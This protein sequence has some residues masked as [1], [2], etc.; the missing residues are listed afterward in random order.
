VIAVATT[1][2]TAR[3][4]SGGGSIG[5]SVIDTRELHEVAF[6]SPAQGRVEAMAMSDDGRRLLALW[7]CDYG[8]APATC[9]GTRVVEHGIDERGETVRMTGGVRRGET[10]HALAYDTEGRVFALVGGTYRYQGSGEM[11]PCCNFRLLSQAAGGDPA[12]PVEVGSWSV[13][14]FQALARPLIEPDGTV[15]LFGPDAS[16]SNREVTLRPGRAPAI[17]DDRGAWLNSLGVQTSVARGGQRFLGVL[18]TRPGWAHV[19]HQTDDLVLIERGQPG[20]GAGLNRFPLA[21]DV[22]HAAISADG[23]RAVFISQPLTGD[24]PQPSLQV[25]SLTSG[26]ESPARPSLDLLRLGVGRTRH[27]S[28]MPPDELLTRLKALVDAGR[29]DDIEVVAATLGLRISQGSP[30]PRTHSARSESEPSVPRLLGAGY[31]VGRRDATDRIFVQLD[32]T[33]G[34]EV[35]P[36]L[37]TA[38][39]ER[40]FGAPQLDMM[41][42]G[43]PAFPWRQ[44]RWYMS[45]ETPTNSV[46]FSFRKGYCAG[47]VM[48]RQVL[49]QPRTEAAAP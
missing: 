23:M 41:D 46:H 27:R 3:G 47:S 40:V 30:D 35:D 44:P 26:D 48:L 24:N 38:A 16:R 2:P 49:S 28:G 34:R 14:D 8:V 1:R 18:A 12:E 29:L 10:L 32:L 36:C 7:E 6:I 25:I 9:A 13:P 20:E 15:R 45:Y 19:N 42:T 21:A 37:T 22:R 17:S 5:F 33:L 4:H 43:V 31:N 39:V 11:N